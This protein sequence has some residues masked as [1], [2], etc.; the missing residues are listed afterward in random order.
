MSPRM[1]ASQTHSPRAAA[2]TSLAALA[3][4]AVFPLVA[5]ALG[6][7]YYV[8][9]VMR[10]LITALIASS[11][12]L[13]IGYGGLVALGHAGFVGVGAYAFV[14][15]VEAGVQSAWLLWGGGALAAAIAALLIGSISLRTRGVYFIMITL[16][17]AQ[18][19]YYVAVSLRAYGGD[20]GY[21]LTA[22]PELGLGLDAG[23]DRVLYLAV[24]TVAALVMVL[25]HRVTESRFGK[26]LVGIRDNEARMRA[27]GYPTY[28]LKLQGFVLTAAIAG[29]GGAMAI[30][31]NAFVS[32]SS[33]HWSQSAI[34]IVMVVLGGLGHRLGGIVG[35]MVWVVL[36]ES[37]RQYTEYW[38]WPLGALLIGIILFAPQGLCR[39]WGGGTV[40]P[41]MFWW[42]RRSA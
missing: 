7:D 16:A 20:D 31:Q 34:L 17:F 22:R 27:L 14:A 21:N 1:N 26:A 40:H 41:L 13:L 37:L 15:L 2:L 11:L 32:P 28:W 30:T 12:N 33:M 39:S 23:N 24:L 6:L 35:A 29:L 4:L 18:M 38:H 36:E 42:R 8:S 9:F 10:L 25:L 19:L 3:L 5:P